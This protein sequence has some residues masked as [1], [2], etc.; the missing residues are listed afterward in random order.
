MGVQCH[1]KVAAIWKQLVRWLCHTPFA[2]ANSFSGWMCTYW[3]SSL[4]AL[5]NKKSY[6][7]VNLTTPDARGNLS[8]SR[9]YLDANRVTYEVI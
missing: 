6:V 7:A 4:W 2:R 5:I 8:F 9:R 3:F 1:W